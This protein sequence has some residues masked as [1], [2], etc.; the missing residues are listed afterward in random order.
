MS[1]KTRSKVLAF[2]FIAIVIINLCVMAI[3]ALND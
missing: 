1:I 2:I 3:G